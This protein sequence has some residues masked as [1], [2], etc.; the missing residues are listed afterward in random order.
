[1]VNFKITILV[2][3]P[4]IEEYKKRDIYEIKT[5]LYH[6][7]ETINYIFYKSISSPSELLNILSSNRTIDAILIDDDTDLIT[8]NIIENSSIEIQ[9]IV[10]NITDL[11]N[12]IIRKD[13]L[14]K[15]VSIKTSKNILFSF[16]TCTFNSDLSKIKNLYYSMTNQTYPH[17][18]W[19]ILDDSTNDDTCEF[20]KSLND[21]RI[22]IFKNVTNHA[23]IGF[24]KHS[25]AM[26]CNGD[27][28]L[29]VDHDDEL[30]EDCLETINNAIHKFPK[31]KFIYSDCFY[32]Y[33][34]EKYFGDKYFSW[35]LGYYKI[36]KLNGEDRYIPT[37]GALN[38][39]TIKSILCAPNHIRAFEKKFY[40]SLNGHNEKFSILDDLDLLHRM[41]IACD[42]PEE[43]TYIDK[44]IY[45]QNLEDEHTTTTRHGTVFLLDSLLIKRDDKKI[46][47]TILKYGKPDF[48]WND[49]AQESDT[50]QYYI[51]RNKNKLCS[52]CNVYRPDE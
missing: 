29:E 43:I 24:N 19:Y 25:I 26:L 21:S 5:L 20:I 46:H 11:N 12:S 35:N 50:N 6:Q 3:S 18:N 52:L 51:L 2:I 45:I 16:Y 10:Y 22:I 48:F 23:N 37:T 42:S 49:M 4:N 34:I 8:K 32:N 15:I 36:E 30:T 1:M 47:E 7:Q 28:L 41:F 17:W 44:S 31:S 33:P 40:H 39:I 38:Q 9:Q 13:I 14:P 27:W